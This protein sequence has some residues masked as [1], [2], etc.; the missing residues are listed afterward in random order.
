MMSFEA[1]CEIK[2]QK[3][4]QRVCTKLVDDVRIEEAIKYKQELEILRI[5]VEG[6]NIERIQ[7]TVSEERTRY[8]KHLELFQEEN[9]MRQQEHE[10]WLCEVSKQKHNMEIERM[11][12]EAQKNKLAWEEEVSKKRISDFENRCRDV[13]MHEAAKKHMIEF[14]YRRVQDDARKTCEAEMK[15]LAS[16]RDFFNKAV[17]E[18]QSKYL[19][20]L[21]VPLSTTS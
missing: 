10:N 8:L 12:L 7:Q 16:Q 5:Q 18:I 14:E 19:N 9:N 4:M 2:M 20:S 11:A 15:A 3:Q 6:R 13:E 21:H 1:E 17:I